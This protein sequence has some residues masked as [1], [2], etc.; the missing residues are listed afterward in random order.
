MKKKQ[1]RLCHISI[2]LQVMCLSLFIIVRLL[3]KGS[4]NEAKRV[5]KSAFA[6]QSCHCVV[7]VVIC[8]GVIIPKV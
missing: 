6:C 8:R 3:S 2:C 7:D 4:S 1:T 5:S